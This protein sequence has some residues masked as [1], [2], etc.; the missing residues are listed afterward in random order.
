MCSESRCLKANTHDQ[1]DQGP[2]LPRIWVLFMSPETGFFGRVACLDHRSRPRNQ[3]IRKADY[4]ADR[5]MVIEKS[6]STIIMQINNPN[7]Y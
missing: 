1:I 7:K 5:V 3:A 6:Q 4:N 2:Q